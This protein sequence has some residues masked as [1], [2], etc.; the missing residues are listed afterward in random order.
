M[1]VPLP[2]HLEGHGVALEPMT[3]AHRDGLPAASNDG[4]L[5]NL[6]YTSVPEPS[7]VEAYIKTALDGQAAGHMLPWVVREL[8][9]GAIVGST[10]Y[11]DIIATIA[12]SKSAGRGTL[13]AGNA[14]TSIRH[15]SYFCSVTPS[16]RCTVPLS[17]CGRTTSTSPR[18]APLP[19]LE[20]RRTV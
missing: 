15:A 17:V 6:W 19:R 7:Q 3:A 10:R 2:V 18:N 8:G 9:S 20:Q 5:W 16:T 11:H 12:E 13:L 1:I 14:V 4:N